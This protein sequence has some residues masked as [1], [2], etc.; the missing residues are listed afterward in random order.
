MSEHAFD[1]SLTVNGE[2]VAERVE[3]ARR[4]SISCAMTCS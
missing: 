4:W 1:I 3:P 2:R